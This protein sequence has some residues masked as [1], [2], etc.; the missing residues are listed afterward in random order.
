[1]EARRVLETVA[2]AAYPKERT[3]TS[4]QGQREAKEQ[5][6]GEPGYGRDHD[7]P[8]SPIGHIRSISDRWT[9]LRLSA[10]SLSCELSQHLSEPDTR[11]R[12]AAGA[13]DA[14][15]RAIHAVECP[16]AWYV[17]CW[18][19]AEALVAATGDGS[20]G[21]RRGVAVALANVAYCLSY[22]LFWLAVVVVK[23]R[24]EGGHAAAAANTFTTMPSSSV[25]K[26]RFPL[27]FPLSE[28]SITLMYIVVLYYG[29][30]FTR[31]V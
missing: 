17:I 12:W 1:M 21:W 25:S 22:M 30:H 16:L 23:R 6:E 15:V 18:H 13:Y 8:R 20:G 9:E 28:A 29:E 27:N 2:T 3:A 24:K 11:R 19:A 4:G 14:A 31:D 10:E 5:G 26:L 7:R